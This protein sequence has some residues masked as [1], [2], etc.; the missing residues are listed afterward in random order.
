MRA[1]VLQNEFLRYV[2]VWLSL[3]LGSPVHCAKHA[4]VSVLLALF[5]DSAYKSSVVVLSFFSQVP[6]CWGVSVF[7]SGFR[8][9]EAFVTL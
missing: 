7:P 3:P 8:R 5:Q 6:R 2:R 9:A 4:R 1:N